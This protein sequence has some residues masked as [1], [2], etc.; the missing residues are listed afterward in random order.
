MGFPE[1]PDQRAVVLVTHIEALHP[2]VRRQAEEAVS[3]LSREEH[4]SWNAS[5]VFNVMAMALSTQHA[6]N[7]ASQISDL[8][9]EYVRHVREVWKAYG[10]KPSRARDPS[11][12]KYSRSSPVSCPS[13]R[14]R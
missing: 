3:Q 14:G 2:A 9:V 13:C 8:L 4:L 6:D 5:H 12:P 11:D 1:G 7:T 10:L